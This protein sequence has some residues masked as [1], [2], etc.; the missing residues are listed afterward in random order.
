MEFLDISSG[1][2]AGFFSSF[3]TAW[4][5]F[6]DKTSYMGTWWSDKKVNV[7]GKDHCW[8]QMFISL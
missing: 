1:S 6:E 5:P 8:D 7:V 2:E 3:M 4:N